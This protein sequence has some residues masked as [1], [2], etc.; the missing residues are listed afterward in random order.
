MSD[1]NSAQK[2]DLCV[3]TTIERSRYQNSQSLTPYFDQLKK[4]GF[5]TALIGKTH[6]SP[7]P[8]SIDH[9]DAH[10]GNSD[11]RGKS[12]GADEFLETY[13]VNQTMDWIDSVLAKDDPESGP[14]PWY[15]YTSMVSP[16]PPNWVPPGPWST[17][18]DGV[19]L[20]PINY[21]GGDIGDLPFQTRMLLGLLGKELNDPPAFPN[22]VPNMAYIDQP[23]ASVR[24]TPFG[25]HCRLLKSDQFTKTGSG[26]TQGN[27]EKRGARFSHAGSRP[28]S[29]A[30]QLLHAGRLC[31]PRGRT[32]AGF[33]RRA[34]LA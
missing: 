20:P 16:H 5:A 22:G 12:I 33:H 19:R 3:Y 13:L 31:R 9:L 34:Q 18:Y 26:Q 15:C 8:K 32:V 29:G 6:F 14:A 27:A 10:T 1:S 24:K 21:K 23:T 17:A 28:S 11:K 2:L 7:V 30:L 25:R 4:V